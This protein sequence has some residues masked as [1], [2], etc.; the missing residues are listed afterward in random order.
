MNGDLDKISNLEFYEPKPNVQTNYKDF[1]L[2]EL[3]KR[4]T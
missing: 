1:N 2:E 3:L 4:Q